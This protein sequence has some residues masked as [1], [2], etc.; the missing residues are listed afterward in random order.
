MSRIH[1]ARQKRLLELL[2]SGNPKIELQLVV[3]GSAIL[4]KYGERFLPAIRDAGFEIHETLYN[5]IEGGNHVT[6]AKTAGLTALESA[7]ILHKLNPDIVLIRGD[8]FEQ[9]AVAMVAAYLNKTVAHIE[10]GDVTGTI[11]ESVRHAITKLSHVH[12]VTNEDSRRRVV[13]MGED[14]DSVY[15]VGSLD[16]EFAAGVKKRLPADFVNRMGVGEGVDI[17][18]PFLMV[19]QHPVTTEVK[20]REHVEMTLQ[21][22]D[23]L[24]VPAVWFW[25]NS[26]AGTDEMAKAIRIFRERARRGNAPIHFVTD[27]LPEDFIALLKRASCLVG[28][29]SSGIK[30]SSYFGTPVVNI[31]TRQQGRL[32]AENVCDAGYDASLITHAITAQMEHGRYPSSHIYY[33]PDTSKRIAEILQQTPLYSQKKFF[34]VS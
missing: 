11:D 10:G 17:S 7:N 25:P 2:N 24:K 29:S 13:Q 27:M 14:P 5:V 23:E 6:M 20:N 15:N 34:E 3:G 19:I 8:R 18:K 32:R 12:F 4:E 26:D 21:A 30:E 1:Y 31:G 16:V 9:L 28:N 22:V 33:K